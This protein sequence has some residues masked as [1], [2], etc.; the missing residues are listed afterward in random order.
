MLLND[1]KNVEAIARS[2]STS[3]KYPSKSTCVLFSS[4]AWKSSGSSTFEL[5]SKNASLPE[6]HRTRRSLAYSDDTYCGFLSAIYQWQCS[7]IQLR[8]MRRQG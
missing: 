3:V 7:D 5:G 1:A 6:N 4:M 8:L 2:V